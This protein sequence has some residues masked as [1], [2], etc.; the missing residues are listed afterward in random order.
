[1]AREERIFPLRAAA[2]SSLP[3]YL[4]NRQSLF[5][6]LR[7]EC[8]SH[9]D[10]RVSPTVMGIIL[11]S[12]WEYDRNRESIKD[13]Y[14]F[15]AVKSHVAA[16]AVPAEHILNPLLLA[17]IECI[18]TASVSVEGGAAAQECHQLSP[19]PGNVSC[20]YIIKD[21]METDGYGRLLDGAEHGARVLQQGVGHDALA[22]IHEGR[23]CEA[24]LVAQ[25]F[26]SFTT[27]LP[28]TLH[29]PSRVPPCNG[30]RHRR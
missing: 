8:L 17:W 25:A 13:I 7:W 6:P 28:T 19:H 15:H 24:Y 27:V 16:I 26:P 18:L 1:M 9:Y 3:F 29:L 2:C 10:G 21:M 4:L 11:P 5:F 30:Q 20:Q 22:E 12:W 23:S 14:V